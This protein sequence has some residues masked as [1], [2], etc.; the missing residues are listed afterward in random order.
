MPIDHIY[1]ILWLIGSFD[2][3]I[4]IKKFMMYIP[5]HL[6]IEYHIVVS[7]VQII[8]SMAII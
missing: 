2:K 4:D 6:S 7:A 3:E 8:G 5:K 1:I